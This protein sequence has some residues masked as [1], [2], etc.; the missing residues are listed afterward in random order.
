MFLMGKG[1]ALTQICANLRIPA[2][3]RGRWPPV[4]ARNAKLDGATTLSLQR[5]GHPGADSGSVKGAA[6]VPDNVAVVAETYKPKSFV[7][8]QMAAIKPAAGKPGLE[9]EGS[10]IHRIRITLT[11][12][13]VKN[14]EKGETLVSMVFL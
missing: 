1:R 2:N 7:V 14:L 5:P 4:T 3:L 12:R 6:N 8:T 9:E 13:N 11:S 10:Q